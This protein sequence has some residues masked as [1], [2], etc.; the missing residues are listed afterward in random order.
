M[1]VFAATLF[2]MPHIQGHELGDFCWFEL[3]T[4]DQNRA[5]EF[6]SELFGW[7]VR[8]SP[9]GPD[10]VYTVF[11]LDGRPCA[12]AYTLMT[13]LVEKGIPPHWMMYVE[14]NAD[15][16]AAKAKELGATM[17]CP[18]MD[19]ADY[20]RMV[21]IQDPAGAVL[22]IWESK[23]HKGTLITE[24]PGTFC[25]G[26]LS[27]QQPEKVVPFY[28]AMFGWKMMRGENPG[29]N[30]LHIM[31]GQQMIG[32]V[33]PVDHRDPNVPS[34]WM[35]YFLV[36]DCDASAAKV[37][38]MG[39]KIVFGPMTMEKV[40]RMAYVADPQGAMFALFQPPV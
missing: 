38:A 6:Y 9:M 36:T 17:F 25:W 12:A 14:G 10:A 2:G 3:G 35:S 28:E 34:H 23:T 13:D 32:G 4:N 31:N 20:G 24:V 18:P 15:A 37:T 11:E 39:G 27:S 33:V 29:D 19:V 8:D 16:A 21:T 5:K 22:S 30:Y 40:G 7:T 1:D 26:E